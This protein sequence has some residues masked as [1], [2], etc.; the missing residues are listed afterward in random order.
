[1]KK[2]SE[3][4]AQF[5]ARTPE[6]A[7]HAFSGCAIKLSTQ[8]EKE[9]KTISETLLRSLY[10]ALSKSEDS[11]LQN[12]FDTQMLLLL[13]ISYSIFC[14]F[15][16]MSTTCA[17]RNEMPLKEYRMLWRAKDEARLRCE[18][19]S[20]NTLPFSSDTRYS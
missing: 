4:E 11:N 1:M 15:E 6:V 8:S 20:E 9:R 5:V 14:F 2:Y 17:G 13:K 12:S 3:V 7:K 19:A 16:A 10:D 18:S